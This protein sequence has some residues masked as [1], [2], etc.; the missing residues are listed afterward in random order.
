MA[1][2]NQ[3][4]MWDTDQQDAQATDAQSNGTPTLIMIST[5]I[6]FLVKVQQKKKLIK[7]KKGE[8]FSYLRKDI[9]IRPRKF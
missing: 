4:D 6:D 5:E 3:Q 1:L 2:E 9:H 7:K 8:N